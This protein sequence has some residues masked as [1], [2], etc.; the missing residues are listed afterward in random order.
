[1]Y[2]LEFCKS[3]EGKQICDKQKKINLKAFHRAL[4]RERTE[5][6]VLDVIQEIFDILNAI[7]LNKEKLHDQC[8]KFLVDYNH[9]NFPKL[10]T[11]IFAD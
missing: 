3:D 5:T 6:Q 11:E 9:I 1:M 4:C 10:F 8:S 7:K 2:F